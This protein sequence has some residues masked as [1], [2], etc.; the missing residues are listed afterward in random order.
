MGAWGGAGCADTAGTRGKW[1]VADSRD[2][3]GAMGE[4][5]GEWT[6][7]WAAAK[8]E[9]MLRRCVTSSRRHVAAGAAPLPNPPANA[10]ACSAGG[11]SCTGCCWGLPAQAG[12]D[13]CRSHQSRESGTS[14]CSSSSSCASRSALSGKLAGPPLATSS[15]TGSGAG[16]STPTPAACTVLPSRGTAGAVAAHAGPGLQG[17]PTCC[18][19]GMS[20]CT[21]AM[22]GWHPAAAAGCCVAGACRCSCARDSW[23]AA[24]S[25]ATMLSSDASFGL[26]AA[27]VWS[28]ACS[29]TD[30]TRCAGR[31]CSGRGRCRC[32]GCF[33]CWCTGLARFLGLACCD[34]GCGW[35]CGCWGCGCWGCCRCCRRCGCDGCGCDGCCCCGCGGLGGFGALR[36][37]SWRLPDTRFLLLRSSFAGCAAALRLPLA[38]CRPPAACGPGCPAGCPPAAP[39]PSLPFSRFSPPCSSRR[40]R[41]RSWCRSKL[42]RQLWRSPSNSSRTWNLEH[43]RG[44]RN[45]G[46]GM[47]GMARVHARGLPR[48]GAES[49]DADSAPLT[50]WQ[51]RCSTPPSRAPGPRAWSRQMRYFCGGGSGVKQRKLSGR[52]GGWGRAQWRLAG[53]SLHPPMHI[54]PSGSRG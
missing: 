24:F 4:C 28:E 53:S 22:P 38:L 1:V 54:S 21:A 19:G 36:G 31:C 30:T 13:S 41:L 2:R 52:C 37:L 33:G 39:V 34:C 32:S 45:V 29:R 7:A 10:G 26:G 50:C 43:C 42:A 27:A 16:A 47:G 12:S 5:M 40:R 18:S 35:G 3:S 15:A 25:S 11:G 20:G 48:L 14:N 8:P 9:C 51:K 17:L 46:G 44:G 23:L 49:S 6:M